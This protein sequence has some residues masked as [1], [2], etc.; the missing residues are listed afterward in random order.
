[1]VFYLGIG[2]VIT[3]KNA[4][5]L[6]EVVDYMPIDRILVETDCPYLAPEPYRGKRN[7]SLLLKYIIKEIANIKNVS[8]KEVENVTYENAR[9][10]YGI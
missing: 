7:S 8:E 1:M 4:K 5:A 6:K 2:G 10:M 9:K 3:F